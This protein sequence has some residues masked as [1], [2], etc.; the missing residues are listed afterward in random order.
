[1]A[2][3][4]DYQ[5]YHVSVSS[6]L[7][8]E[9]EKII[10]ETCPKECLISIESIESPFLNEKYTRRRKELEQHGT[11]HERRVF[12]GSRS[13]DGVLSILNNGFKSEFNTTSAF[14]KGTYFATSYGYS[15][16][17]S[18]REHKSEY[19]IMLICDI[20]YH[21]SVHGRPNHT[22]DPKEGDCW[23]DNV[24]RPTIFSVPHDDQSIPRYLVRFF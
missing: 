1:M 21:K 16:H 24:S 4:Q 22:L 13:M 15:K 19:K 8:D 9:L 18:S 14:G 10:S 6:P 5:L 3:I 11:V 23:V 7:F 2:S 12:H 17:Y 20:M